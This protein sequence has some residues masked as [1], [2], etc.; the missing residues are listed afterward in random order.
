MHHQSTAANPTFR[1]LTAA[2]HECVPSLDP[3]IFAALPGFQWIG[4]TADY[5]EGLRR[6]L[7]NRPDIVMVPWNR[8]TL[9][10][11][12]VLVYLRRR[13]VTTQMLVVTSAAVRRELAPREDVL[14]ISPEHLVPSLANHLCRL[15]AAREI[16][17]LL[18][19]TEG[20]S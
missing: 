2:L 9:K 3:A 15:L 10:L 7:M 14:A 13:D 6:I 4:D 20:I 19:V 18:P 17:F 8:A 1:L 16:G 5:N 12:E 11:L